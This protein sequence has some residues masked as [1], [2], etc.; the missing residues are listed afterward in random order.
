[1]KYRLMPNTNTC[2]SPYELF[3]K[4]KLRTRFTLMKSDIGKRVEKSQLRMKDFHD[5]GKVRVRQFKVGD[6]LQ[7]QPG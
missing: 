4:S 6:R 3:L 1:M 7:V 2:V 5:Q